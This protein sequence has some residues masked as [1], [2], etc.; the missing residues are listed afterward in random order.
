M[1]QRRLDRQHVSNCEC[2][3][4]TESGITKLPTVMYLV[5]Q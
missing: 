1:R 2:G 3:W 5:L 4:G